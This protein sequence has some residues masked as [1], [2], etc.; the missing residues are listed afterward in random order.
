[1]YTHLNIQQSITIEGQHE[2]NIYH[3][4]NENHGE[5]ILPNQYHSNIDG[6]NKTE[7]LQ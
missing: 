4:Q 7:I 3:V 6:L 2:S 1:N 5:T